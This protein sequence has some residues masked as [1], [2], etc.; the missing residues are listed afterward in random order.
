MVKMSEIIV[1]IMAIIAVLFA[2]G[3]GFLSNLNAGNRPRGGRRKLNRK[4]PICDAT[5]GA[6]NSFKFT[7][8]LG[9]NL[10]S[11]ATADLHE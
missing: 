5:L 2:L 11:C 8:Q 3:S 1:N 10:N 4:I 6:P 9:Q 7:P